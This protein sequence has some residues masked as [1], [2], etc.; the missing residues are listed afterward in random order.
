MTECLTPV[1]V[2]AIMI[3]VI[4]VNAY[5]S[6]RRTKLLQAR[7]R[8]LE[9][10]KPLM[11]LPCWY[12]GAPRIVNQR[13]G[14][15]KEAW[16]RSMMAVYSDRIVFVPDTPKLDV[17]ISFAIRELRWFGRPKKYTPSTNA[18][19]LHVEKDHHWHLIELHIGQ[20]Q[21]QK[22]VALLKQIATPEQVIAYR[23]QRP[24]IH[25]GPVK[26]APAT[27]DLQGAWTLEAPV[28]LYLMPSHLVILHQDQVVRALPLEH[29]Q[30]I[31]LMH[32]MDAPGKDGLVRFVMQG[33]PF[34]FALPMHEA[35]AAA[36]AEAAK[37][38]LEAP[39]ERK[40]K[41]KEDDTD[42][43]DPDTFEPEETDWSRYTLGDDGELKEKRA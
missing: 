7:Y 24:Y 35:L 39:L 33:E 31:A 3:A 25:Y 27:Q 10:G 19:W 2:F 16:K 4:V 42:E 12:G 22:F 23:R 34:A 32:R 15:K 20:H 40:G 14:G 30:Q 26:A 11:S 37:R 38:S 21:M 8:Q 6:I 28:S 29:I 17:E 1:A 18:I 9:E 36:L 13:I 5:F 41:F 43:D